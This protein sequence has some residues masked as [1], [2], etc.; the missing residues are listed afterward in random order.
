MG[1]L[2]AVVLASMAWVYFASEAHLRSF[3][4]PVPF[5]LP[6]PDDDAA[7]ARGDHLVRTRGCRGCHGDD[8][9]GELMWGM[10]LAVMVR[11]CIPCRPSISFVCVMKMWPTS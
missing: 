8:L 10:P 2:G 7:R 9:G 1:A 3:E 5:A 11:H 6:I 4:P